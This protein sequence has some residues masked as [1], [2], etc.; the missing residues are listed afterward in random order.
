MNCFIKILYPNTPK[1]VQFGA[2]YMEH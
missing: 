2:D 1:I